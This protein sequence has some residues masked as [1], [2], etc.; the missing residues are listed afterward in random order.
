MLPV[1]FPHPQVCIGHPLCKG[2]FQYE[3][4]TFNS[5]RPMSALLIA[6]EIIRALVSMPE[7]WTDQ[8]CV[9]EDQFTVTL[10]SLVHNGRFRHMWSCQCCP[11]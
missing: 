1:G 3:K 10:H 2:T 5:I 6:S 9:P 7:A 4:H 11:T 8:I